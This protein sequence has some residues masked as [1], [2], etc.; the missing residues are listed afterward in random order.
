[1][2]AEAGRG[3]GFEACCLGPRKGASN[4]CQAGAERKE[5]PF[6]EQ[7]EKAWN[8]AFLHPWNPNEPL[9]TPTGLKN[10][11]R[12]VE[13]FRKAA[14]ETRQKYGGWDVAW[15]EV[16]R[17]QMGSVDVPI[18]DCSGR[19]GCFRVLNF[20]ENESGKR[21]ASRGDAWVLAVEFSDPPRAYSVLAYGQNSKED[22]PHY[23]DQAELF[24]RNQM[25]KVAFTEDEIRAQLLRKYRPGSEITA[26]QP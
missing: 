5:F 2:E 11:E 3:A 14:D 9:T 21:V 16:H 8:S 13:A 20:E 4:P 23:A 12:A 7:R 22:S 15:G 10:P 24:A 1:M 25:K 26:E 19:L 6:P 18:G 17:L